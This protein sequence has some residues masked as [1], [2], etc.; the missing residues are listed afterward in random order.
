MTRLNLRALL[1]FIALAIG[2]LSF[3]ACGGDE[4]DGGGD[5]TVEETGGGDGA[6]SPACG[7]RM[8]GDD[9]CGGSCG[10]CYTTEGG[11]DDSLCADGICRD[12]S[13]VTDCEGKACGDD[14]CGG[15]CGDCEAGLTCSASG[16]C[17]GEDATCDAQG[18]TASWNKAKLVQ[19]ENAEAWVTYKAN[20][21]TEM[22]N[23]VLNLLVRM[24]ATYGGPAMPGTYTIGDKPFADEGVQLMHLVN[25]GLEGCE[26]GYIPESG[27]IKVQKIGGTG[28]QLQATLDLVL[29]RITQDPNTGEILWH[30]EAETHCLTGYEIDTEIRGPTPQ[31]ECIAEGDGTL[32][33][34]NIG[35][36]TLT[37]C[38][39]E[40]ISLHDFCGQT[41]VVWFYLT[42]GWCPACHERLP[43]DAEY[44][45]KKINEEGWELELWVI[46]G[47]DQTGGE[48]TLEFCKGYAEEHGVDP[49]R[50]FVD[51]NYSSLFS[52]LDPYV[53]GAWGIPWAA[54]LD[55]D[56][57]A[58]MWHTGANAATLD[59]ITLKKI[60]NDTY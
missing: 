40:E 10:H 49:A 28:V 33:N 57:M 34:D 37:N 48:P 56:N 59:T 58:Y 11:I 29:R 42:A 3:A 7:A 38:L 24:G 8:C 23:D 5:T 21:G 20:T 54:Y 17:Q 19:G 18:F 26:K 14:G 43:P 13:C 1:V 45:Y 55:G 25:C 60:H 41:K 44:A 50:T 27:T 12:A 47:E 16:L 36:V 22:P 53:S 31:P 32:L 15:S 46:V 30:D 35:D 4:G 39:G 6:C 51:F 52:V 9:G 2:A